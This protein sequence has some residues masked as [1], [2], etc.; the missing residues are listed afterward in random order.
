MILSVALNVPLYQTFYYKADQTCQPG[1]R[2]KVPFGKRELVGVVL[3]C[4]TTK[5]AVNY[6]IKSIVEVLDEVPLLPKTMLNLVSWVSDY[7]QAPI[8]EVAVGTLPKNLRQK[9]LKKAKNTDVLIQAEGKISKVL[10]PQ[11]QTAV[12]CMVAN[13]DFQVFVL[14]GVTGSGKTEVYLQTIHAHLAKGGQVLVLVPEIGLTPQMLQRFREALTTSM[15]ALHSGL[16]DL[17][18]E[19]AWLAAKNGEAKVVIGTRSSVFVPLPNLSLIILDEEHDLSF[20]QQTGFQYSARDVAIKRAQLA[21]IPVVLGSA[22]PSL[23]TLHN[24]LKNKYQCLLL[25]SRAGDAKPPTV[26]VINLKQQSL[27]AGLSQTL[28]KTIQQHL[29]KQGQV[30]LFLNRRG[31]APVLLC[32][33]CGWIRHC[34]RCDAPM[35]MHKKGKLHCH[36]CD[37]RRPVP[38]ACPECQSTQLTTVG[39][40]TEQLEAYLQSQFLNKTIL[41]IDRDSTRHKNGLSEQLEKVHNGEADIIV[42]TQML[43]KGHHF[44][45]LTLVV[46]VDADG[47]L[48]SLDFRAMEYLGQQ[49]V[50]VAGRAGREEA[51]GEVVIQTH[52]PDHPVLET[53]LTQGYQAFAHTILQE[54]EQANLPPFSFQATLFAQGVKS[55]PVFDFLEA[56]QKALP[57]STAMVLGPRPAPI[58]KLAGKYRAEILIQTNNRA[59]LAVLLKQWLPSLTRLKNSNKV[60]WRMIVDPV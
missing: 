1:V 6:E 60:K 40:G 25:P 14:Q 47:G 43:T 32:H 11:Q 34:D 36:H 33:D 55:Q 28:L 44:K 22:T 59:Q 12:E 56:A 51:I 18:R 30:L 17:E 31:F 27:Q 54:R 24:V 38:P 29:E 52:Y 58:E 48:F 20:R 19:T 4:S 5:P 53:L 57:K 50:Q 39:V 46:I 7:Y 49:L 9:R 42:G 15:V 10:N 16:T 3:A 35:V 37:A 21:N 8:G 2:V 41:R 13:S 45:N 26:S 23:T